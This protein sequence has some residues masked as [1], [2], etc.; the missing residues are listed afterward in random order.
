MVKG[1]LQIVSLL[2]LAV[3]ITLPITSGG[4]E[5]IYIP[6]NNNAVTDIVVTPSSWLH[7]EL[8]L[9]NTTSTNLTAFTLDNNGTVQVDVTIVG[10]NSEGW[11][12]STSPGYNQFVMKFR[13]NNSDNWI[14]ITTSPI[15][16]CYNL[17]HDEYKQFGLQLS[18][19][20][21]TSETTK[22]NWKITF[23]ATAD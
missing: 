6:M 14:L 18:L 12:L 8:L 20:T 10:N 15:V 4:N 1:K 5:K 17:S 23:T 13:L 7:Y 19:P 2:F 16:F 21:S 3:V 11:I 9:A 22:Q